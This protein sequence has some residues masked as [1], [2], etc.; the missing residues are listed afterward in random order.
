M[1]V[2]LVTWTDQ[3]LQKLSILNPELEYCAIVTDEVEPAKKILEQVGLPKNLLYPLYE[4]K[5]CVQN[6]YYDY[7]LCVGNW[8][9][10]N[11]YLTLCEENKIRPIMFLPPTTNC[12]KKYFNRQM[13]DEF[14]YLVGRAC[15]KHTGAIFIDGWKLQGLTDADFYDVDHLNI[16]GAAKFSEFLNRCIEQIDAQGG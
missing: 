15:R 9:W 2:L 14:Y 5:E 4:L 11:D 7:V 6:F 10:Q 8:W 16:Q 13:L 1:R 12:Y 3:L